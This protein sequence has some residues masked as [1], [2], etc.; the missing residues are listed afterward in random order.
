VPFWARNTPARVS[1]GRRRVVST[2]VRSCSIFRIL[3]LTEG[4]QREVKPIFEQETG[5]VGQI[6]SILCSPAKRS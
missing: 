6:C 1:T 5:E 3:T 4:Q 2:S